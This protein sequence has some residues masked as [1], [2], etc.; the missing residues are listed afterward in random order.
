MSRNPQGR[1]LPRH[2]REIQAAVEEHARGYGLD[3][4]PVLFEVLS[5]DQM[6]E[7]ASYGGFPRRYPHWRFGMEFERMKKSSTYGLHR[8]Y[9]MVI[10]NDPCYA[11][12]LEGNSLVDQ[13]MVMAHVMAHCD[14]FKNNL[15]FAHTNRKMM[16]A[17]ANHG[18]RIAGY[19][20]RFGRDR[21]E[22]FL[23][24]CLSIDNLIDPVRGPGMVGCGDEP[25]EPC[26]PEPP[27]P[28]S[29]PS[30]MRPFMDDRRGEDGPG[31]GEAD[32]R[33]SAHAVAVDRYGQDVMGFL[34]H[35]APLDGWEQ[36]VLDIARREAYYFAPQAQTKI[37]NEGWATYWHSRIMT[38]KVLTAADAIEYADHAS[39]VLA[40][41]GGQLNP[42]KLGVE[43]LRHVQDR[44]DK[45]RFGKDYEECEDAEARARW[46]TEA[47][48]GMKK[49]FE[50]RRCYNDVTF[51]DE[52]FDEEFCEE[53]KLFTYGYV[54]HAKRWEVL[55]RNAR[56]VKEALLGQLTNLGNPVIRV[57]DANLGNAGELLLAHDHA[58]V[59]LKLSW[60]R[61]TLAN[62]ER[63]WRR[64][65]RLSTRLADKDVHL[66]Y[67]GLEHAIL[68]QGE[69]S[70]QGEQEPV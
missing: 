3:F 15:F 56:K 19:M 27:D 47:G 14:F 70:E 42:Y 67:D 65:V 61:D 64:P 12:L 29:M 52:F 51:V 21:V 55:S 13:K 33:A 69:G 44:W 23:D 49:L 31:T 1:H 10:N 63:I 18:S 62:L 35:H 4:Y 48:L 53:Q 26:E 50:V 36:V 41:T 46:D 6:D 37:M 59:D 58:G 9:E 30:Y 24:A 57:R 32:E 60:A 39:S 40:T 20:N 54:D 8:I 2:L 45:G 22:V 17:M 11:Y 68:E 43:L 66:R 34:L 38:E 25:D 16:D 7:V 5:Y 28:D